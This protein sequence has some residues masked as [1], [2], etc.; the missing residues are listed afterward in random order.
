MQKTK[1]CPVLSQIYPGQNFFEIFN[2]HDSPSLADQDVQTPPK[3]LIRKPSI[4]IALFL[5]LG[6]TAA[7]FFS[8]SSGQA[9][10]AVET[11]PLAKPEKSV[12]PPATAPLKKQ[13]SSPSEAVENKIV[14]TSFQP[15]NNNQSVYTLQAEVDR[16]LTHTVCKKIND[17]SECQ[18]LAAHIARLMTWFIKVNSQL[19]KGDKLALL[20]EK[21]GDIKSLK[22]LKLSYNSSFFQKTFQANF[23]KAKGMKY[24]AY[25]DQNGIEIALHIV[26][27]QAPIKDYM[28]ITSLPGEMRKGR[29]MG[30]SGSDFKAEAG[31]PVFSSFDGRVLR[32][33]WNI[34]NNGY[35]IEIDHPSKGLMTRYLHMSRV[36]VK[37]GQQVRAGQ[38]IGESGNTGRTF[39]PH[40]HFE[41]LTRGKRKRILNPFE[42]KA[43]KTERKHL[44]QGEL[45]A[46]REKIQSFESSLKTS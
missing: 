41:L 45:A 34:R 38:K 11:P 28:E 15:I 43:I 20:Y 1:P 46:F 21:P 32:T 26:G 7:I 44:P 35:C 27:K 22:I 8:G 12:I 40:L 19:R 37:P 29:R 18:A 10:Q 30:H 13:I 39:A 36:L 4:H 23:Y 9:G 25:Y 6:I 5:S 16:S 2:M 31:A 33:Q 42:S 24:G 17:P 3:K 14:K